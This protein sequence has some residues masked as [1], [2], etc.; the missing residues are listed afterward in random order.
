MVELVVLGALALA[1]FIVIGSLVTVFSLVGWIIS[2][3]FRL[4]GLAFK[5]LGLLIGLPLLMFAGLI[6]ALVV[7][8][9]ALLALVPLLPVIL[10]VLGVVWLVRHRRPRPLPH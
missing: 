8:V 10:L 3:P 4:V 1:A 2:L 9:G 7:G 5:G 6:V